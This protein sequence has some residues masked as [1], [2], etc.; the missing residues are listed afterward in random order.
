MWEASDRRVFRRENTRLALQGLDSF[1]GRVAETAVEGADMREL[2]RFFLRLV[3]RRDAIYTREPIA[4]GV[5]PAGLEPIV[6]RLVAQRIL[7]R[8]DEAGGTIEIAHESL[9]RAWPRMTKWIE[10]SAAYLDWLARTRS[11]VEHEKDTTLSGAAG[12][13]LARS[14]RGREHIRPGTGGAPA[15]PRHP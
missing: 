11:R 14:G 10:D 9:L 8:T 4:A 13:R 1:L 12:S 5:V 6:G 7:T 15:R 3:R 2:E